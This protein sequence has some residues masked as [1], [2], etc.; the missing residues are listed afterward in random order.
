MVTANRGEV[1]NHEHYRLIAIYSIVTKKED[2][3]VSENAA[4]KN[5]TTIHKQQI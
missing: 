5:A 4:T 2:R 1:N 3:Q